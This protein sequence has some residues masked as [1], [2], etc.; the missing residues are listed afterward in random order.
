MQ[1]MSFGREAHVQTRF[2]RVGTGHTPKFPITSPQASSNASQTIRVL[3]KSNV[4]GVSTMTHSH[5]VPKLKQAAVLVSARPED[6]GG[7]RCGQ[8]AA[9]RALAVLQFG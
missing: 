5:D 8:G 6:Q 7:A 3:L 2:G 1:R 9:Q 4:S